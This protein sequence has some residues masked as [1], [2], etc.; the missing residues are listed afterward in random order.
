LILLRP[1]GWLAL[2][3]LPLLFAGLV[4]LRAEEP[5]DIERRKEDL[6]VKLRTARA[7]DR[8]AIWVAAQQKLEGAFHLKGNTQNG[9]YPESRHRFGE[10]ALG[11]LT[12]AHCGYDAE[13]VEIKRAVSYLRKHYRSYLKGDYWP[14]ASSYSLCL[15]VLALHELYAQ[16]PDDMSAEDRERYGGSLRDAKN[17]CRY[18]KWAR[19]MIWKILDWLLEHRAK[20][21]LFRY[22]QGLQGFGGPGP[23]PGVALPPGMPAPGPAHYGPEDL[24]NSQYVLLA[25]WV[26]S[27]CGY[28][29][30]QKTL[31]HIAKR[32]L[33]IQDRSGPREQRVLDPSPEAERGD[34]RYG[35]MTRPKDVFDRARGFGYTPGNGPTGSMTTAGLSSLAIVKAMLLEQHTLDPG[36]REQLDQGIWDAIA[37]LAHHYDIDGN[38]PTRSPVW[39]YYYLYGLE[40]ACVIV[41]KKFLGERDWYRDG[42]ILLIDAQQTD[43]RWQPPSAVGGWG[44][45]PGD[46]YDTAFQ[47]TCF[48][49]L[50]L[51][52]AALLP[53]VPL[54]PQP[55]VTPSEPVPPK[56]P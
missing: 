46:V 52:R 47:D 1:V 6:L 13:R 51:K 45:G 32:L 30:D 27:R 3:L 37:W 12:L 43:G 11:T 48:A 24:S 20:E 34:S 50:F 44:G 33:A 29:V 21:G 2:L 31:E 53:K 23:P 5:N 7:I 36:L 18:P 8:G 19:Q 56:G 54:L 41:G 38:P 42:A 49:L 17:P 14:Q 9:P 4:P 55:V 22:P 10:S 25:L 16:D 28:E 35:D 15:V 26:G 39:H 40:R